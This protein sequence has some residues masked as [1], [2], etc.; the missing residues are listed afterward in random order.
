[1]YAVKL[2]TVIP[3]DRQLLITVPGE[4]PVGDAEVIILSQPATKRANG[5]RL[6]RYILEQKLSSDH[7]RSAADIDSYIEQERDAWS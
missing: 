5:D 1:M 7:R 3:Q 6:L 2:N 4:V